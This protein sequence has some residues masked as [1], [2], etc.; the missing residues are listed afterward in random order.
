MQDLC[1]RLVLE[2]EKSGRREGFEIDTVLHYSE[3]EER[4]RELA[5]AWHD[6]GATHFSMR[7]MDTGTQLMGE[8]PAGFKTVTDHIEGLR[9][10]IEVVR[11]VG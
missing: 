1:S 5:Q 9:R 7:A 10:F 8:K 6:L 4:W 11:D 2:L 3:G